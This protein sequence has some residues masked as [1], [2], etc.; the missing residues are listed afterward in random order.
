MPYDHGQNDRTTN[1]KG[2]IIEGFH[3][4]P[5]TFGRGYMTDGGEFIPFPI[6]LPDS[7][8]TQILNPQFPG[9]YAGPRRLLAASIDDDMGTGEPSN[10]P[11]TTD[12]RLHQAIDQVAQMCAQNLQLQQELADL[13]RNDA[14][15]G[16][17]PHPGSQTNRF[18]TTRPPH[19]SGPPPHGPTGT[20]NEDQVLPLASIKPVLLPVPAKFKGEHDDID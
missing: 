8:P 12:Q 1:S 17:Q 7:P 15:R 10:L 4:D 6:P 5:K 14:G 11:L 9:Y 20:W 3:Y 16:C 13:R 2:P 18:S 19:Y